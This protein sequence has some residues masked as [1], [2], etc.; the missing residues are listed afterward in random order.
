M[1]GNHRYVFTLCFDKIVI[2]QYCRDA[3]S[4][5]ALDPTSGT[6]TLLEITRVLGEMYRN[7]NVL[8]LVC[9]EAYESRCLP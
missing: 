9:L 1:I 4:L 6:A 2:A 7:G 8:Y 3:W 5:G